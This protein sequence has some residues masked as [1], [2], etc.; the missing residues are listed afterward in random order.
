MTKAYRSGAIGALLDEYERAIADLIKVIEGIPDNALITIV[1]PH[2]SDDN[3]RSV[4]TVLTHVVHAGYGYATSIHNLKGHNKVRPG[5]TFHSTVSKYIDDLTGVFAY[6]E[7]VLMEFNDNDLEQFDNSL[8]IQAGWGQVY[9]IEQMAEH[10]IVH[11]LRH[12]RQLERFKIQ[13]ISP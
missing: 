2:T 12:R 7:K 8:K 3:C 9:D 10:A 13:L 5:K 6:T 1:D 11:I 4:Q